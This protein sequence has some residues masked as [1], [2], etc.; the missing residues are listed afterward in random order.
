MVHL[1]VA[2]SHDLDAQCAILSG[3]ITDLR[4]KRVTECVVVGGGA[5]GSCSHVELQALTGGLEHVVDSPR[6]IR[7]RQ[8][9]L[10]LLLRFPKTCHLFL[11]HYKMVAAAPPG[12]FI[13]HPFGA[14]DG[15]P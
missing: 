8:L 13:H 14:G 4:T 5:V 9:N 1:T 15:H 3:R 12:P 7:W 2:I 6:A 10:W 11:S